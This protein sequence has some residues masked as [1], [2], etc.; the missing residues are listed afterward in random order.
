[1]ILLRIRTVLKYLLLQN[2]L[3][4]ILKNKYWNHHKL[5]VRINIRIIIRVRIRFIINTDI[6]IVRQ[7]TY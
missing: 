5:K 3:I 6:R 2:L 4:M 7:I 1:M